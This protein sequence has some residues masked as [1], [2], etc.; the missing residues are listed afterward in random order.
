M[1]DTVYEAI[2]KRLVYQEIGPGAK[3]NI[4]GLAAELDVSPTPVRE[5]LARLEAEGLVLKRPMAG[6][7]AAPLMSEADFEALF[8]MRL[9]LEPAAAS[10]AAERISTGS[11]EVLD[12]HLHEMRGAQ[13]G[14]SRDMRLL[15]VQQD[16]LFHQQIAASAGNAL[17]ADTLERFHAH[18]HL[19][20]LYF[21]DGI[22]ETTCQEHE[23]IVE[24]LRAADP[25][26]A[27]AAMRSHLR[28]AQ[29]RLL[30]A[31]RS[32]GRETPGG[33]RAEAP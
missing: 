22:T 31:V 32:M 27:A 26:I 6:Y 14:V 24:A 16:A 28:R 18:T 9:L 10:L 25:D 29:Q 3:I 8:E 33:S 11:L 13:H 7:S 2:R 30:P 4:N 5:A 20:R 23:R 19:Y 21:R 15:F 17:M 1:T 12:E